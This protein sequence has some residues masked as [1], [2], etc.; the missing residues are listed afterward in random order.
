MHGYGVGEKLELDIG[1]IED[2]GYLLINQPRSGLT[3]KLLD[4]WECD[5]CNEPFNWALITIENSKIT[6]VKEVEITDEIA[7]CANYIS[8]ICLDIGYT[9]VAGKVMH[10]EK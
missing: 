3:F 10:S 5:V 7:R 2:S 9:I 6:L 8:D 1:K 4:T